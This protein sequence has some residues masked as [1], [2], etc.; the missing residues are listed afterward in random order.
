M[1]AEFPTNLISDYATYDIQF[2]SARRPTHRN[3][4]WDQARFEVCANKYMDL[5]EPD[6]GLSLL[7]DCKYGHSCLGGKMAIT[8][9]K[10]SNDPDPDCNRGQNSFTYSLLPH[11]GGAENPE[12]LKEAYALN[13]P[14][15]AVPIKKQGGS[16]PAEY[17][18]ITSSTPSVVP[19]TLKA[20]EDGKGV[21]VRLL[22]TKGTHTEAAL[23]FGSAPK[24]V[25]LTN[26]LEDKL[27]EIP[28]K[29]GGIKLTFHPFE[30]KTI[31]LTF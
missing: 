30:I 13:E 6:F 1:K 9:L 23:T 8:L 27:S 14:L 18:F 21:I 24:T 17:S 5:S 12:I 31:R 2:G 10:S 15:F 29:N 16:L 25:T 4:S 7:N 22:E 28:V 26:I 20:A 3:T 11:A 19:E